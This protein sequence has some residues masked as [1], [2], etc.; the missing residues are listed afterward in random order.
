MKS[1]IIGYT[2]TRIMVILE[3]YHLMDSLLHIKR[4]NFQMGYVFIKGLAIVG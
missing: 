3:I 2:R 1:L 4:V